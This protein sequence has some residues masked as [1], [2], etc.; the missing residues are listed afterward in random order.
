[1]DDL[2]YPIIDADAHVI[3]SDDTWDF[4]EP[5]EAKYRPKKVDDPDNPGFGYWEVNGQ[6]GPMALEVESGD[7]PDDRAQ[8]SNRRVGTPRES[9]RM[10]DTAKRIAHMDELGID[11][12]ILHT[13]IWLL[14]L[15]LEPDG[16]AALAR[17]WNKWLAATT[18]GT[19]ERLR[20]SCLVPPSM[21]DEA[22][23][24]MRWSKEH[25]ACAV[26]LRPMEGERWVTDPAF[27]PILEEAEKL[28]LPIAI[29][30][31]NANP[32][33]VAMYDNVATGP[34]TKAWGIFRVPTVEACM[35]LIM[36]DIRKLFPKLRWGFIESAAQWVPWVHNESVR[37]M[38]TLGITPPDNVF[39]AANI[40]ITCQSDDDLPW[41]L[42][43]AGENSLMI[44][45]DYGHS[46]PSSDIDSI[47]FIREADDLAAATKERILYRNPAALYGLS[48][49]A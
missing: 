15:T 14:N 5:A 33:N 28:D 24:Q 21:P 27:Y 17:S 12:Q 44:G 30:I 10:Q 13:T 29:H 31:A 22:V 43:Y 40:Y 2:N 7:A 47:N 23:N 48:Q 16:E 45:T 9:R 1:M 11:V 49:G 6:R 34:Q 3:E 35:F 38:E 37:R 26:F 32:A 19:S 8:L 42:K 39:E 36:S 41:V 4:L 25:G 18:Q 20:W 46:D